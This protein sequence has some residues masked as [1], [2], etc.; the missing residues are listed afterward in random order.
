MQGRAA[1]VSPTWL[2]RSRPANA[3]DWPGG[4]AF[5]F[6]VVDDTDG[7]TLEDVP[8]VYGLLADLGF[9]TTKSVWPL[10]GD[11]RAGRDGMACSDERSIDD[12]ARPVV[13]THRVNGY[14]KG[15]QV[16]AVEET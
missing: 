8:S 9:R 3:V 13:A 12:G 11:D 6:S 16:R 7:A 2:P 14:Y 5:A 10:C 1:P 15:R 4:K